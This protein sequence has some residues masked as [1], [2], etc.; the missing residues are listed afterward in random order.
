MPCCKEGGD[1]AADAGRPVRPQTSSS[2]VR[3]GQLAAAAAAECAGGGVS[4]G[5]PSGCCSAWPPVQSSSVPPPLL[6]SQAAAAAALAW[7]PAGAQDA[8]PRAQES[9]PPAAVSSLAAAAAPAAPPADA[10]AD[11]VIPITLASLPGRSPGAASLRGPNTFDRPFVPGHPTGLNTETRPVSRRGRMGATHSVGRSDSPIPEP[12]EWLTDHD[13]TSEED[14][15]AAPAHAAIPVNVSGGAG[16]EPQQQQQQQQQALG[17][18]AACTRQ[19]LDHWP[20][21]LQGSSGDASGGAPPVMVY[22]AGCL[23]ACEACPT[24]KRPLRAADFPADSPSAG[25]ERGSLERRLIAASRNLSLADLALLHAFAATMRTMQSG[26]GPPDAP[27]EPGTNADDSSNSNSNRNSNN[28]NNNSND[29]DEGGKNSGGGGGGGNNDDGHGP[30]LPSV[31]EK[32][33]QPVRQLDAE[34]AA[35]KAPVPR[36][37]GSH[38]HQHHQPPSSSPGDAAQEREAASGKPARPR[39]RRKRPGD[40]KSAAAQAADRNYFLGDSPNKAGGGGGGGRELAGGEGDS[41]SETSETELT[42]ESVG[43]GAFDR[44]AYV[45]PGSLDGTS[46]GDVTPAA[47]PSLPDAGPDAADV[48]SS[49][50]DTFA[51]DLAHIHFPS[52]NDLRASAADSATPDHGDSDNED[53]P[54]TPD[55]PQHP[56]HQHHQHHHHHHHHQHRRR[57]PV[58]RRR[59]GRP[60][61]APARPRHR[62][63][64]PGDAKSAAAQAADRNYFLGDSPNKAGGGGG[65]GRELAGGEGDSSSETSETELTEESVG[66]GAF[67]RHAYV[68]P[69]SLDGTSAGDVTPAADPSLPDAGPDAAD[70]SSS[71]DDTFAKDLA[72]IHFPSTND[73]RA[74]AADSA[75]P[76]HG[77]SDNEDEPLTPDEPQEREAASGKPARPRH[78]RKRPGDAKSAAAQAADRNYFLG[79]SPNKAGGGGGGGRE[80]A[81]GEGDSSSETSETELT[82]ESVGVGAFDRH[83]YVD[84]GSLDGTS[85]GDVTPAAD[86]SLPDAGPDAADVSPSPDA[87]FAKDLAHIHFPSTNDLRAS[88]ADSA[89]PDHG[90]SDNEDEPLTPDEPQVLLDT[91]GSLIAVG[92]KTPVLCAILLGGAI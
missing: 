43:V 42:E 35:R 80:L 32:R 28:N 1:A 92:H 45:D 23:D 15:T 82:E 58:T 22:C 12:T 76:D 87:T 21:M 2:A 73:L 5:H 9:A 85:A 7:P 11:S 74:S 57:H 65:G 70:V 17:Q 19:P 54:L 6:S 48:S 29:N 51:K 33:G 40:A 4:P 50:D 20:L 56:Q 79:D 60:L 46:A 39:H 52:T 77:D 88:A 14:D 86:P 83:A 13:V 61:A 44:H 36:P 37:Q 81:G 55:E 10:A 78:R 38:H 84:P 30:S 27:R 3:G 71:A 89:T 49:A 31:Q 8:D 59:S 68:D 62:R 34:A 64:R 41:T 90:D 26:R 66:V 67:D 72:H 69:G 53:E 25:T 18:A 63:K 75:T 24:C 91:K 16:D 47:D